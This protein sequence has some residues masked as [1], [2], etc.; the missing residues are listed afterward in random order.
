MNQNLRDSLSEKNVYK[1]LS[2]ICRINKGI[3][4]YINETYQNLYIQVTQCP[5]ETMKTIVYVLNIYPNGLY[6]I[7]IEL[8]RDQDLGEKTSHFY[9]NSC[10]FW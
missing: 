2:E 4:N 8:K 3:N 10:R 5:S 7:I 1:K 9:P 6:I